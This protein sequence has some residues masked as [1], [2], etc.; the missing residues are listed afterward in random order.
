VALIPVFDLDGTLL[1]S[2]GALVQAFLDL[3]VPAD[4]ITFG[5]V[6]ADECARLGIELE[7]YLAAYDLAAAR[8][9]PGADAL[10]AGLDRW[11]V[12]SNKDPRLGR[13]ELAR[14]GWAPEVALFSDAFDGPK[15]LAPVLDRLG[16]DAG[17]VVFVGDTGHDR[18]CAEAVGARFAVAAWN[19]RAADLTGDVVLTDPLQLRA[20]LAN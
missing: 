5:H 19:P 18:T 11:A 6:V 20:M 1:D 3:G 12:C 17:D 15:R 2:D 8:P 4:A 16:L 7:A 14:L 10:V 9:F 13:P